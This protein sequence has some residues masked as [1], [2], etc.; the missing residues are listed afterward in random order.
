MDRADLTGK[1]CAKFEYYPV[2]LH[3][4]LPERANCV[5]IVFGMLVVF[6]ERDRRV[7]LV[8]VRDDLGFNAQTIQRR[9]GF[10]V[11][12]GYR[13]GHQ[14]YRSIAPV[15]VADRQHMVDEVELH[16]E[17]RSAVRDR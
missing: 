3:Q 10:T 1:R 13:F 12:L 9:E 7:N 17:Y 4:L 8:R 2:R 15:A 6:G 14:R 11:E 5:S 16:V